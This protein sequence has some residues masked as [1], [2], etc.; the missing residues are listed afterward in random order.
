MKTYFLIAL[1]LFVWTY[2]AD[3]HFD[4]IKI[5]EIKKTSKAK[6]ITKKTSIVKSQNNCLPLRD[7]RTYLYKT[8]G[9]TVPKNFGKK[10]INIAVIDTGIDISLPA[11]KDKI[12]R[13][14]KMN[15]EFYGYNLVAKNKKEEFKPFDDHGHGTHVSGIIV[16]LFPNAKILP[17]KFSSES[18]GKTASIAEAIK[19]AIRNKVHIINIS[20]GGTGF[21]KEENDAIRLAESKGIIVV[22]ASGNERADLSNEQ[23][24]YYPASYRISNVISV[25]AHDS[26]GLKSTFSNYGKDYSD[27]AALGEV[28]SYMP[29]KKKNKCLGFLKGTSQATPF[30][31]ATVAMLMSKNPSWNFIK[32]KTF[33]LKNVSK[34]EEFSQLNFSQGRLDISRVIATKIPKG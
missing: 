21:L 25:M 7:H 28:Y 16:G 32:V 8:M 4:G 30:V 6:S 9:M 33:L 2:P 18:T 3:N 29:N 11:F 27:I 23:D 1:V 22:A 31:S 15:K 34:D 26:M 19:I 13:P 17:I 12:F 24:R 5:P 20:A 14:N 10:Q